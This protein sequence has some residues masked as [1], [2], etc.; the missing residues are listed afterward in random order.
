MWRLIS[1]VVIF[2]IGFAF[3]VFAEGVKK[4]EELPEVVVTATRVETPVESAPAS[5][6]VVTKKE[7]EKRNPRL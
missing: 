6:N 1:Y 7:M 5:V 2:L 4:A 3:S